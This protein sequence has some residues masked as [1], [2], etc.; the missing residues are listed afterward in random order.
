METFLLGR[1]VLSTATFELY[2]FDVHESIHYGVEMSWKSI[3]A[4]FFENIDILRNRQ[5]TLSHPTI[6]QIC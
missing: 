3:Y 1:G 6:L 5:D 2:H 4:N